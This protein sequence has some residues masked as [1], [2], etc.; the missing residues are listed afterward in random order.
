MVYHT[1]I[2]LKTFISLYSMEH[3]DSPCE[4]SH[5]KRHD[6]NFLPSFLPALL[7]PLSVFGASQVAY[8]TL[9]VADFIHGSQIMDIGNLR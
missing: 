4:V 2:T 3:G 7:P 1:K 8:N 6:V 9:S 5:L